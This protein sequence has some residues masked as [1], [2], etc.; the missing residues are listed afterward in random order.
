MDDQLLRRLGVENSESRARVVGFFESVLCIARPEI[1]ASFAD[2]IRCT[3]A[4][5]SELEQAKLCASDFHSHI[6]SLKL[7]LAA[8]IADVEFLKSELHL[9]EARTS[10]L[11]TVNRSMYEAIE[12]YKLKRSEYKLHI[13]EKDQSINKLQIE[14]SGYDTRLSKCLAEA[15]AADAACAKD[16]EIQR[17][18]SS[19]RLRA[20]ARRVNFFRRECERVKLCWSRWSKQNHDIS[21]RCGCPASIRYFEKT[22]IDLDWVSEAA[23]RECARVRLELNATIDGMNAQVQ[24]MRKERD[25]A[26]ADCTMYIDRLLYTEDALRQ[27]GLGYAAV[28]NDLS[29]VRAELVRRSGVERA[30]LRSQIFAV[31]GRELVCPVPTVDGELISLVDVYGGWMESGRDGDGIGLRFNSPY[32][33]M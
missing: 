23:T 21:Q 1:I 4:R 3:M 2:F 19:M 15:C 18:R 31:G 32:T 8:S 27:S 16:M 7:E 10:E 9:S 20:L 14:L 24:T 29:V 11:S 22:A 30:F 6:D 25:D 26:L 33:G 17:S 5:V 13:S 12:A 28:L